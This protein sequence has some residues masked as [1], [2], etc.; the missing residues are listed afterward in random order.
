MKRNFR[1]SDRNWMLRCLAV[2]NLNNG[3][4]RIFVR[5]FVDLETPYHLCSLVGAYFFPRRAA[6]VSLRGC[7]KS[8]SDSEFRIQ[9]SYLLQ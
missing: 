3:V 1:L 9:F 2:G 6:I 4:L 7:K 8:F 5:R